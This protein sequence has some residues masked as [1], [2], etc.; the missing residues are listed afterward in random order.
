MILATS[1]ALYREN[2]LSI[3]P[4]NP[5]ALP[6]SHVVGGAYGFD[7]P[8]HHRAGVLYREA[9]AMGILLKHNLR[10]KK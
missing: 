9:E 3:Y 8:H 10:W 1:C 4:L 5:V 7:P 2:V 6:N